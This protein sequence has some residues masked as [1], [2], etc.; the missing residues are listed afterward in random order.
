MSDIPKWLTDAL[1]KTNERYDSG[2]SDFTTTTLISPPMIVR[3]RKENESE[4]E[5]DPVSFLN[6]FTGTSVHNQIEKSLKGNPD[7]IVEERFFTEIDGYKIS[8]QIDLYDKR[9][10]TL[11]DHKCTSI[12]KITGEDHLDYEAQLNIN[13]YILRLHG[14]EV[15]NL[16][17]SA[18]PQDWR[19]SEKH[20]ENYP[21]IRYVELPMGM[22]KD[23]HILEFIRERIHEH[24][25]DEVDTCSP[26][27][28]WKSEDKFAVMR[29]G[30]KTAMKL[31]DTELDAY[32]HV[33][34]LGGNPYFVQKREGYNR[35]CM[36]YCPV[37]KFCNFYNELIKEE[38]IEIF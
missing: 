6:S 25:M 21:Q 22:W 4:I 19:N 7:Y 24:T 23:E 16:V 20:R 33:A 15:N 29:N 30:R 37:N 38:E 9:T 27:D 18:F 35:R 36:E 8:G 5:V 34:Q 12:F 13:A 2:E 14:I 11:Y 3:L 17:I 31:H 1:I 32:K 26:R 28:R 10:K